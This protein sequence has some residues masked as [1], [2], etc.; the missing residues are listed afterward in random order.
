MRQCAYHKSFL[1]GTKGCFWGQ[2]Y[3]TSLYR[4]CL[5]DMFILT[6]ICL[7]YNVIIIRIRNFTEITLQCLIW[8]A[9][10]SCGECNVG[11]SLNGRPKMYYIELLRA[12]ECFELHWARVMGY[13]PFFLIHKEGINRM[14]MITIFNLLVWLYTECKTAFEYTTKYDKHWYYFGPMWHGTE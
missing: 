11:Q 14:M 12:S 10:W 9:R 2:R 4:L 1:G 13:G 8:G 7:V 5:F 3:A 6:W